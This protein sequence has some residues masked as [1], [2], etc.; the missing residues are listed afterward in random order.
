VGLLVGDLLL[1]KPAY[2]WGSLAVIA[3]GVPAYLIM[4]SRGRRA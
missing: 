2:T 4:T 1:A 3:S